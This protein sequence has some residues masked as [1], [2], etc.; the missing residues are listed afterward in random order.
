MKIPK[1]T[2]LPSGSYF[3]QLRINGRSISI[4]EPT[5]ARCRAKALS[6]KTGLMDIKKAPPPSLT[7][8]NAI[9][10]YIADRQCVLSPLTIRGYRIIQKN[11]FQG[12]MHKPMCS[13][14]NWQRVISNEASQ[15]APKT[16]KNAWLFVCSVLKENDIS[17]PS[18]RLPQIVQS[19]RPF[20]EPEQIPVFIDAV[21]NTPCAIPALLALHG[22]R[23]SE[24]MALTWENVNLVNKTITIAG[25][26]VPDEN[27]NL[28]YK[29]TN[30][31]TASART[32]P[33]MIPALYSALISAP[34]KTG[35]IVT[36]HPNSLWA[37]INNICEK[38]NLPLVGVH[39]LRHSFAS[40]AY[41]L[42]LS[43]KETML[44]GGWSDSQTMR[45]IYTHL[46]ERDRIKAENKLT[47]FFSN[48]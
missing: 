15:C 28:V 47:E 11:R 14:K 45:K 16:I 9:D 20:L 36:I 12:V 8:H 43:E 35:R 24:L 34:D 2:K 23:R 42:G 41:H 17:I 44:L 18:V 48:C 19:E 22:L 25:A 21:K 10:N 27:N 32:L 3:C 31:T 30:K 13:I 46:A 6:I 37:K 40:L 33:I 29:E 39:G 4:T 5:E 1:I 26:I 38:N 7:L